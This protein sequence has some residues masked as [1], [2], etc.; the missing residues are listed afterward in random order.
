MYNQQWVIFHIQDYKDSISSPITVA[1]EKLS[2]KLVGKLTQDF[3][4][5]RGNMSCSSPIE[6]PISTTDSRCLLAQERGYIRYTSQGTPWFYQQDNGEDMRTW[7]EQS[8][9]ILDAQMQ[10]LKGKTST[11]EF[12]SREVDVLVSSRQFSRQN[13][14]LVILLALWREVLVHFYKMLV[15]NLQISIRG[16]L[17]LSQV[18]ETDVW[19]YWTVW[20]QW[21]G[22]AASQD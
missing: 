20:V 17:A 21:P 13:E 6:A 15:G 14:G 4:D 2:D 11:V 22:T 7:D 12:F 10:E 5:F 19:V 1:V 9:L 3:Q 16:A 8:T 18:E